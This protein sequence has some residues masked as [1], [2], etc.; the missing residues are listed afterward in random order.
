VLA[1]LQQEQPGLVFE[2]SLTNRNEDLL[3][4]EAD[5][6]VR[7]VRP[8]QAAMVATRVGTAELGLFATRAYLARHGTPQSLDELGRF[9][10]VGSDRETADLRALRT[11]GLDLK[12][13][14]FSCRS[15]NQL[16]QL[17]AIRAGLGIGIC[18]KGIARRE[19]ALVPVLAERFC[20]PLETW[21]AMHEDL[22]R[23]RRVR[24]TFAHLVRGLSDYCAGAAEFNSGSAAA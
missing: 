4:Q 17:G 11:L 14:M 21:V 23:V 10:L 13:S 20:W 7:M 19:P 2:L 15:D 8:T 1:S 18:Q 22:R 3:R 5:I 24:A 9:A 16:A 12:R 6:A